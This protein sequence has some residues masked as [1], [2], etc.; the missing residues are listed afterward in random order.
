MFSFFKNLFKRKPKKLPFNTNSATIPGAFGYPEDKFSLLLKE[1]T[2]FIAEDRLQSF[3]NFIDGPLFTKF[4][5][6]M[7]KPEHAALLGYAFCAAVILQ[8]NLNNQ[9][10]I[11]SVLKAFYPDQVP[12]VNGFTKKPTN[13]V[14]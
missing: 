4:E 9:K 1:L 6:N 5:L 12:S 13:K 3:K 2:S 10:A 11:N 14:N 8:A 7:Q